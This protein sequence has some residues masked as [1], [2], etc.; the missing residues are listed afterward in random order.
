[1]DA[2]DEK[3]IQ[4]QLQLLIASQQTTQHV[5]KNQLKILNGTLSHIQELEIKLKQHD[6]VL[7]NA[8]ILL[9]QQID[10][11]TWEMEM[12]EHLNTLRILGT[13]LLTDIQDTIDFI[14]WTK[15]GIINTR[16]LPIDKI[17][18]ELLHATI[19]LPEGSQ[20]PFD[21]NPKNWNQ[22]E[23]YISITA[24]YRDHNALMIIIKFPVVTDTTYELKAVIP[25]PVYDHA[26]IFKTIKTAHEYIA[27]DKENNK[28]ITLTR[29]E[30]NNCIRGSKKLIC[31]NNFA[32]YHISDNAPCEVLALTEPGR[33]TE[34]CETRHI[35]SNVS[36]WTALNE[37]QAW[38]YSTAS[39]T[40][41][42]RCKHKPS[43]KINIIRSGKI[44][45]RDACQ[46]NT[47]DLTIQSK[48]LLGE[49]DINICIPTYNITMIPIKDR[50][51]IAKM[52]SQLKNIQRE[53]I[54]R[55]KNELLQLSLDLNK[56]RSEL[57]NNNVE[58]KTKT[59]II[60][61]V[62]LSTT[63]T[64]FTAIIIIITIIRKKY[65]NKNKL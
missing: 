23:K 56:M 58:A 34:K 40:I 65:C 50:T 20:F 61:S 41:E 49:S 21:T 36:I 43:K 27:L 25:F 5:A 28:Y 6:R 18:T 45:L 37:P 39:Q 17:I 64:V 10:R 63:L 53:P 2:N 12:T 55:N 9:S 48:T 31:K 30:I 32:T 19:Q 46:L 14:S 7:T 11:V 22:I 15:K 33:Q 16:L 59:I 13:D 8:T 52:T 60:Y 24:H 3:I 57:D 29:D 44:I 42:L 4:E 38:L 47:N 26:N 54:V 1:M 51:N 62:G 35:I